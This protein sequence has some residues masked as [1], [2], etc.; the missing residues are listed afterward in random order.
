MTSFDECLWVSRG[1]LGFPFFASSLSLSFLKA[2]VAH[3][4][5]HAKK[6]ENI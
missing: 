1:L 4:A 6:R 2:H 3:E 5:E